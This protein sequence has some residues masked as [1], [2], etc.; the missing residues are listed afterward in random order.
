MMMRNSIAQQIWS[1]RNRRVN[2]NSFLWENYVRKNN[3][4]YHP[5]NIIS[6]SSH[7]QK[8]ARPSSKVI[9]NGN[10]GG[11][12]GWRQERWFWSVRIWHYCH[13]TQTTSS[14]LCKIFHLPKKTHT[15][16]I[17][18]HLVNRGPETNSHNIYLHTRNL[19]K[20]FRT[21]I[22]I[23]PSLFSFRI[24]YVPSYCN[25]PSLYFILNCVF[26]YLSLDKYLWSLKQFHF[27]IKAVI[28]SETKSDQSSILSRVDHCL[29]QYK[30]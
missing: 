16:H 25:S 23:S 18:T 30:S 14:I 15:P 9:P 17:H 19:I 5:K 6:I 21:Q 2:P 12:H 11:H 8:L 1:S 28:D 3:F 29:Q 22:Q 20:R 7:V 24:H 10:P 27:C 13:E 4:F 26:F